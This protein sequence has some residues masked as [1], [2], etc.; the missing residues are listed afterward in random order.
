MT[1]DEAYGLGYA[2]GW[3]M[4]SWIDVPALGTELPRDVDFVGIGTIENESDQREAMELLAHA[5]EDN[6]RQFSP[7]EFTARE[8]NDAE[9]AEELWDAFENGIID[10]IHEEVGRR[11]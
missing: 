8:L 2:R 3:T 1:Y 11:H 5:A 7:F 9:D 6:D 10:G 4:A